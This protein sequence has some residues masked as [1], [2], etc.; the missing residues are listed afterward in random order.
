[1]A[2]KTVRLPV[3]IPEHTC[4]PVPVPRATKVQPF[5]APIPV[6][7]VGTAD[8][9]PSLGS[10]AL[11]WAGLYYCSG[12]RMLPM[13]IKTKCIQFYM[14]GKMVNKQSSWTSTRLLNNVM[15]HGVDV[16]ME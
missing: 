8:V 6:P 9:Q 3:I 1:M 16:G 13:L 11:T 4:P 2:V 10:S 14:Q 5:P 15:V 7:Q 12:C